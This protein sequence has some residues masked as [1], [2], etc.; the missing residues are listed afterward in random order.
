[1]INSKDYQTKH[2]EVAPEKRM[3]RQIKG[4][5]DTLQNDKEKIIKIAEMVN[6]PNILGQ[7]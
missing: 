7:K 4:K 2:I 3:I 6:V 5:L 1:M